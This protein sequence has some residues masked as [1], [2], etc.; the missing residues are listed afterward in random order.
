MTERSVP[1]PATP[2]F[3][4]PRFQQA[5]K[6]LNEAFAEHNAPLDSIQ[7]PDPQL[8]PGYQERLEKFGQLRGG[9]LYY[10]YL[11][12]GEGQGP[13]VKLA[14][15]S[16]KL[17]F[18]C[19]IGVH[20][21]GH[22]HPALMNAGVVAAMMDTVMQGNLQQF[23]FSVDLC[24][25]LVGL[26]CK[27]G[28][29][30]EHVMLTTSGAMANENSLKLAYHARPGHQR[31][32][33]F[34][35][36]FA[37]RTLALSRLTDKAAYRVGLPPT[38]AVDY[39]PFF[40]QRQPDESTARSLA[41]MHALL[42]R[43]PNDYAA[44][45]IELIQGEGGYN[46]GDRDYLIKLLDLA[47]QHEIPIIFDEVQT[48]ARTSEPFAF[49]HFGLSAYADIVT[50]GKIS[51]VCATL[52]APAFKPGPGLVS[53]TFTAGTWEILAAMVVLDTLQAN[54]NFG[55]QSRNMRIFER[56]VAGFER[57]SKKF[58]GEVSWPLG[59]GRDDR[60]DTPCK[61]RRLKPNAWL[62]SVLTRA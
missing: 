7:P 57:L 45:W 28:A 23:D 41:A 42:E 35:H 36:C 14:D 8:A 17:D 3:K 46:P 47:R 15:G 43:Y 56:F 54:G 52:F 39:L 9:D 51:Q 49:Q 19:G 22:G 5:V 48:F 30:L 33:A 44:L 50:I 31:V 62:K 20:G 25:Q 1:T 55:Q 24:E 16:V 2:L 21:L 53:Q 37:G 60:H 13:F 6:L 18:I 40:D 10:P 27:D 12:T 4:D 59:T 11:S 29:P 34:D 32:L 38:I 26:A 58:P 61:G